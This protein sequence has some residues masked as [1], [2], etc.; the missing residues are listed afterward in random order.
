MRR[1]LLDLILVSGLSAQI[2]PPSTGGS[3]AFSSVTSGTNSNASMVCDTGC[4]ITA[5][6]S[7]SIVATSV[8][9]G[10]TASGALTSN[11]IMLGAGTT[12]VTALG[13]LGTTTTILHGNAAGAP[14]FSAVSLTADVSGTL[15]FGNGGT[16]ATSLTASRCVEVNGA[17]TA[18][19]VAAATCGTGSGTILGSL[20]ATAGVVA[21]GTGTAN[22][23]TDDGANFVYNSTLH[24]LKAGVNATPQYAIIGVIPSFF[25]YVGF[26]GN[27]ALSNTNFGIATDGASLLLNSPNPSNNIQVDWGG[28]NLANWSSTQLDLI[29]QTLKTI[30]LLTK[31]NCASAVSPAVCGSASSGSIYIP[32]GVASTL[33]V[34]TTAVTANSVITLTPDYSLGTKLSATCNTDLATVGLWGVSARVAAT[35]FTV[36]QLGTTITNGACFNYVI[37]N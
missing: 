32:A 31:D 4:S 5:T 29:N 1:L 3:S 2:F 30:K 36:A 33:V 16:G 23:V 17:G 14:T 18:L 15:P 7:G 12:V 24:T 19:T 34:N 10:V 27:A 37:M 35:S 8:T 11:R 21:F 22:T 28:N 25:T 9:G 20:A 13:S 6:G 26:G